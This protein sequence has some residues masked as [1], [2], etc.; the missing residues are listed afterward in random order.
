MYRVREVLSGDEIKIEPGWN[1][2]GYKGDTVVV[3]GYTTPEIGMYGYEFAKQKLTELLEGKSVE[4]YTPKFYTKYGYEKIVCYV[5]LNGVDIS[6]YFP[7]FGGRKPGF[8][9]SY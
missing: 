7:E 4:L 2:E 1:W 3:F 6:N 5:Y 9:G 8:V